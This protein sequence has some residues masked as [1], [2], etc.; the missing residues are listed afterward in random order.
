M[1]VIRKAAEFN[2]NEMDKIKNEL[3]SQKSI[4]Q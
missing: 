1:L 4:I 3:D 2:N